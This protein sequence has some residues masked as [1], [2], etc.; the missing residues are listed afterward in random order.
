MKWRHRANGLLVPEEVRKRFF[1][2]VKRGK[3]K[4]M[5]SRVEVRFINE[6][7][8]V[9]KGNGFIDWSRLGASFHHFVGVEWFARW[10]ISYLGGIEVHGQLS[11]WWNFNFAANEGKKKTHS[12]K[13]TFQ[14]LE[15]RLITTS[16]VEFTYPGQPPKIPSMCHNGSSS[17]WR[18]SN[19]SRGI[20]E[21]FR[22]H[23]VNVANPLLSAPPK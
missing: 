9:N 12:K 14:E 22:S 21:Y 7:N 20:S 8:F 16:L 17:T 1:S 13:W 6:N 11:W 19:R 10:H 18:N 3:E 5:A 2:A 4:I 23:V 15:F